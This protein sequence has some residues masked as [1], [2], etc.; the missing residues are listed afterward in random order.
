M[1]TTI[2]DFGCAM[3]RKV[4]STSRKLSRLR[5]LKGHIVGQVFM[6]INRTIVT[7]HIRGLHFLGQCLTHRF[8]LE[9]L[10]DF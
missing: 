5:G 6:L 3:R 9:S 10:S 7:V 2:A 4:P 1:L 8:L